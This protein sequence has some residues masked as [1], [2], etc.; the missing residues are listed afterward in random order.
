MPCGKVSSGGVQTGGYTYQVTRECASPIITTEA[1]NDLAVNESYASGACITDFHKRVSNGELLPYT[2]W[3]QR[4]EVGKET[5]VYSV[6]YDPPG[7]C[8]REVHTRSPWGSY[9]KRT[10][11]NPTY[12]YISPTGASR[13]LS[14]QD[15]RPYVQKAAAK[16][17]T[18]GGHD[19]LTFLGELSKT[20]QML[21]KTAKQMFTLATTRKV[22]YGLRKDFLNVP[23]KWLEARYGW[24]PLV[25]D[26]QDLNKA[27]ETISKPRK[28]RHKASS[29][30]TWSD[31][32]TRSWDGEMSSSYWTKTVTDTVTVGIRGSVVA[33]IKPPVFRLNP[34]VTG[35]ELVPYSFVVDWV[36]DVGSYIEAMAFLTIAQK[37]Y[38]AGGLKIT[39]NRRFDWQLANF[40]TYYSGSWNVYA[41]SVFE[42]VYRYPT[43]VGL[44]PYANVRLNE[45]KVVDLLTL[46]AQRVGLRR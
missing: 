19:T 6:T 44:R 8:N 10:D 18:A 41:D 32:F 38:A 1:N 4:S 12:W 9:G 34:F 2:P 11:I 31:T 33:D 36:I 30:T 28:N 26:L 13:Y 43:T 45:F 21:T 22:S 16:I 7:S 42:G 5:G 29:G 25:Y 15:F 17:Y 46:A 3:V 37:Y 23:G 40:K 27:V 20:K 24:R 39:I 14:G 35:W